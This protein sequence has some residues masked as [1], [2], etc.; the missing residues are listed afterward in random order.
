MLGDFWKNPNAP[1]S[2]FLNVLIVYTSFCMFFFR[3]FFQLHVRD[4]DGNAQEEH[5]CSLQEWD[6]DGGENL[7]QLSEHRNCGAAWTTP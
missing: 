5:T 4:K 1:F 6:P 2:N 3:F 7:G